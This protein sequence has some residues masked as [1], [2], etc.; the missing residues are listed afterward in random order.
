MAAD[1]KL[2]YVSC[3]QGPNP[4]PRCVSDFSEFQRLCAASSYESLKILEMQ[5]TS[6]QDWAGLAQQK[7][8][9]QEILARGP[10]SKVRP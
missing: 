9:L 8:H 7:Q 3:T 5:I 4:G 6:M 10:E 1:N 2:L